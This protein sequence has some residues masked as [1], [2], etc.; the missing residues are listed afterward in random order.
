MYFFSVIML[1]HLLNLAKMGVYRDGTR[2][3]I[4]SVF[5]DLCSVS[6]LELYFGLAGIQDDSQGC[7]LCSF[8][9]RSWL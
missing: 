7:V 8:E 9:N 5:S 4:A 1:K 2:V 6:N 3:V